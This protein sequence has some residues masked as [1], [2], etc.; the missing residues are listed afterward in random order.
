[1]IRHIL[2][3]LLNC[4][5]ESIVSID[6]VVNINIVKITLQNKTSQLLP[7]PKNKLANP[8]KYDGSRASRYQGLNSSEVG[9]KIENLGT[10]LRTTQS[11]LISMVPI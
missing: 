3:D 5:R 10:R 7:F 11:Y 6:V 4:F 9:A 1:M 2:A 8:P